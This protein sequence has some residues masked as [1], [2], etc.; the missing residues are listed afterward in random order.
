GKLG[1]SPPR[2]IADCTTAAERLR[3]RETYAMPIV[4]QSTTAERPVTVDATQQLMPQP[5]QL[6]IFGGTGDLSWRKLLPAVYNLAVDG[7]LPAHFATVA[8][9]I[10]VEGPTSANPDEWM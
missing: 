4:Q 5:C 10:P 7:V 9:G 8:F 2:S 6:V 3:F 1:S